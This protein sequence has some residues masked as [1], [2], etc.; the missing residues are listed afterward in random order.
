VVK[1]QRFRGSRFRGSGFR[2][3]RLSAAASQTNGRSNIERNPEK[4]NNEY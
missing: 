3:S 2:G 4:A 1:V